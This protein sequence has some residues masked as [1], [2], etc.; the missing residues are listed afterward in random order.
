[1]VSFKNI[2]FKTQESLS[3]RNGSDINEVYGEITEVMAE[4]LADQIPELLKRI[5]YLRKNKNLSQKDKNELQKWIDKKNEELFELKET[6]AARKYSYIKTLS[7]D[8]RLHLFERHPIWMNDFKLC[9]DQIKDLA[10]IEKDKNTIIQCL[11]NPHTFKSLKIFYYASDGNV[12]TIN[13]NNSNKNLKSIT[14]HEPLEPNMKAVHNNVIDR[15]GG[16]YIFLPMP[17]GHAQWIFTGNR[18]GIE[19]SVLWLDFGKS[20]DHEWVDASS[21][22]F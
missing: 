19:N 11:L 4:R 17:E 5:D 20:K 1:M 16:E 6:I 2:S 21:T 18:W 22:G 10:A 15:S 7:D 3:K 14:S 12:L 13:S 8:E 9:F